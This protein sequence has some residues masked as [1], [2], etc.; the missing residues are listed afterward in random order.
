MFSKKRILFN[1]FR[2]VHIP[3]ACCFVPSSYAYV[4]FTRNTPSR[5]NKLAIGLQ[6]DIPVFT[7][8]VNLKQL[9]R[10]LIAARTGGGWQR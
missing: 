1:K 7:F 2:L 5:M 6:E 9:K 10:V 3:P 4:F 8:V